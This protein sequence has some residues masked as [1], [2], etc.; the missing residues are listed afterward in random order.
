[1]HLQVDYQAD[2]SER[3]SCWFLNVR[4]VQASHFFI[5]AHSHSQTL[6]RSHEDHT[7]SRFLSQLCVAPV[8]AVT[9]VWPCT[10]VTLVQ[11]TAT[12]PSVTSTHLSPA[13]LTSLR[14]RSHT[15]S[16]PLP[17]CVSNKPRFPK[18]RKPCSRHQARVSSRRLT[19]VM[20][21]RL[22]R[23]WRQAPV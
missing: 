7:L 10:W 6:T 15:P 4:A 5:A 17:V 16:L 22:R 13:N 9:P 20:S 2:L 1:M 21:G 19:T 18:Q 8:T 14:Q 11:V 12:L 23:R 3:S